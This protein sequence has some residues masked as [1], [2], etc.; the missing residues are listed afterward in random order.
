MN[1]PL[2]GESGNLSPGIT[3]HPEEYAAVLALTAL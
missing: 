1:S 2:K 3:A